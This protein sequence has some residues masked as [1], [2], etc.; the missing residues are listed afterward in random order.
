MLKRLTP[1]LLVFL[2]PKPERVSSDPLTD[3]KRPGPEVRR[4]ESAWFP[5][6][7]FV[8]S[9]TLVDPVEQP[10]AITME[11]ARST[12]PSP[13]KY[14][15]FCIWNFPRAEEGLGGQPKITQNNENSPP[16][17]GGNGGKMFPSPAGWCVIRN[18]GSWGPIKKVS[19]FLL[20]VI[21]CPE[22][23]C[24]LTCYPS[25]PPAPGRW[26]PFPACRVPHRDWRGG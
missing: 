7:I 4:A 16:H 8:D 11:A 21:E 25:P 22:Y 13:L 3:V 1:F 23:P 10:C 9:S 12:N 5:F 6:S 14:L 17:E 26:R 2:F 20:K 19:L 24:R 18:A 15:I